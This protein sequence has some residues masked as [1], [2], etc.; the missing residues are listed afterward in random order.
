M[1]EA[2]NWYGVLVADFAPERARLGRAK[3]VRI[4]RRAPTH[5]AGLP[6]YKFAVFLIAQTDR[7]S[8]QACSAADDFLR[9]LRGRITW[10]CRTLR[11]SRRD[12]D[13][14]TSRIFPRHGDV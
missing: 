14:L 4:G 8:W 12:L 11:T 10:A 3:M 6:R 5:D 9:S 7:L 13:S 1:V 2:T